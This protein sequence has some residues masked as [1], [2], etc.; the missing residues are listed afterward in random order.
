MFDSF[1]KSKTLIFK[2]G[3]LGLL[4]G[5]LALGAT[6]GIQSA[7]GESSEQGNGHFLPQLLA[8]LWDQSQELLLG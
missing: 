2:A 8:R 3:L 6:F 7:L 5:A 4:I 1:D